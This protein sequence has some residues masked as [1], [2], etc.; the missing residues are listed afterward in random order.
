MNS[1]DFLQDVPLSS[2]SCGVIID[3]IILLDLSC[4]DKFF[5]IK[6]CGPYVRN[7]KNINGVS[8]DICNGDNSQTKF[9]DPAAKFHL[10]KIASSLFFSR[11][12]R[13]TCHWD[14]R[15]GV[16]NCSNEN[17]FFIALGTCN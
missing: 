13:K 15:M 14:E 3:C 12:E 5:A 10:K 6:W 7:L 1:A 16:Q 8:E 4:L 2:C 11:C 17:E 9:C